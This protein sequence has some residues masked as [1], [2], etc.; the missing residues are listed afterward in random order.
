[1]P[2]ADLRPALRAFLL[3]DLAIAEAVGLQR[4]FPVILKQGENKPSIVYNLVSDNT[5][6]VTEGPSGLVTARY[7]IDCWSLLQDT[8]SELDRLVKDRLD[9]YSGPMGA[10]D[11]QG[12]FSET[13]WTGYE[14]AS[15]LFRATRDYMIHYGER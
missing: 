14:D 10:I 7:Q 6:H 2:V 4:V 3:A 1:M 8:S 13:G 5:D 9:G 11:V 15:K 12:V